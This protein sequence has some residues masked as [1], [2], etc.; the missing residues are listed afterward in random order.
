MSDDIKI[1]LK[2]CCSFKNANA[3]IVWLIEIYKG[4]NF[5]SFIF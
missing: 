2:K 3:F 5:A 1:A 4:V